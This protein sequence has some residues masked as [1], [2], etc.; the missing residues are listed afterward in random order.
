MM[1]SND[2]VVASMEL[3]WSA[4][5]CGCVMRLM[6]IMVSVRA[7]SAVVVG[8]VFFFWNLHL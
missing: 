1:V 6:R 7:H 8:L 5:S 2:C 4:G 3:R